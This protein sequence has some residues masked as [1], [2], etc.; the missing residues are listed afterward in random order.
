M[1]IGDKLYCIPK[2]NASR[3]WDGTPK[4]A[5][6]E[7]IKRKYIYIKGLTWSDKVEKSTMVA[8]GFNASYI[9]FEKE[10]MVNEYIRKEKLSH[11][12]NQ[13]FRSYSNY[14]GKMTIEELELIEKIVNKYI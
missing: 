8:S 9:C 11:S 5:T 6:I 10:D 1:D 3:G 14:L 2:G 4:V 13:T 12:L 7:S